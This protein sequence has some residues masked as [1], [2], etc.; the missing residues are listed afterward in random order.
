[1]WDWGLLG[2]ELE[3]SLEVLRLG[4]DLLLEGE[5]RPHAGQLVLLRPLHLIL[6]TDLQLLEALLLVQKSHRQLIVQ[7]VQITGRYIDH[8]SGLLVLLLELLLLALELQDVAQVLL[9][10]LRLVQARLLLLLRDVEALGRR[11]HLHFLSIES[12]GQCR[13]VVETWLAL[14]IVL[15]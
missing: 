3:G 8:F 13:W 12:A 5:V 10:E 14:I 15:I 2:G 4:L 11:G 7:N 9:Q 6:P 1:M